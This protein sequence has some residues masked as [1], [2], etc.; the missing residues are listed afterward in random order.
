MTC[1]IELTSN[2][3][4]APVMAKAVATAQ[5]RSGKALPQLDVVRRDIRVDA[6]H[7]AAYD[8]LTGFPLRNELPATYLHNLSFPLQVTLFADRSYPYP[9]M[10]SVHLSNRITQHR[11]VG[12]DE[13]VTL[14]VSTANARAHRRGALVDVLSQ[15]QAGD[16]LVWEGVST[17][18]YR[19]QKAEGAQEEQADSGEAVDGPGALWRLSGDLGRRFA[20]VSGD[21]NPIHMNP[22]AAK[23]L[24]F[25]Q[26]IAH[27]AW[28]MARMLG[29]LE[30]RLPD[31]FTYDVSF[32][33][34]ILLPSTVRFVAREDNGS[35]ALALRNHKKGT[36]HA[37]GTI[38]PLV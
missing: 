9:L 31:A 34:P 14:T 28:S 25:P 17:Y 19:G 21:V 24:G 6:G 32:R 20:A 5:L 10:G 37:R 33:K 26:T 35:W 2:P 3:N 18:L 23:A 13:A 29:A 8:G 11:P 30:N 27:G 1:T 22:L 36:E 15:A 12:L 16:E 4:L 38:T 7:L